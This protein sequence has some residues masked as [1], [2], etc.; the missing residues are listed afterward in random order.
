[1]NQLDLRAQLKSLEIFESGVSIYKWQAGLA[2]DYPR[3]IV[4]SQSGLLLW[5]HEILKAVIQASQQI[6]VQ[7]LVGADRVLAEWMDGTIEIMTD[8]ETKIFK[9]GEGWQEY[10]DSLDEW[11]GESDEKG[12]AAK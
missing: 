3:I 1:V 7:K 5:G 12:G 6:S 2:G 8:H 11:P 4:E 10:W 9:P